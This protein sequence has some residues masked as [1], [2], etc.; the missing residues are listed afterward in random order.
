MK[1]IQLNIQALDIRTK[2][3]VNNKLICNFRDFEDLCESNNF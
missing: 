2:Q 1:N 3:I